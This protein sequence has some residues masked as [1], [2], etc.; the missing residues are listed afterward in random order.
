MNRCFDK[1]LNIWTFQIVWD[2]DEES[3]V[4]RW[5]EDS[6][7]QPSNSST[8]NFNTSYIVTNTAFTVLKGFLPVANVLFLHTQW[9]LTSDFSERKVIYD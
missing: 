2:L 5:L 7:A 8:Y 9:K 3:C 6:L 1:C 4:P